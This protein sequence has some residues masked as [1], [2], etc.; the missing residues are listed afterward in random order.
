[1]LLTTTC[2]VQG[3]DKKERARS[4]FVSQK[5]YHIE[6]DQLYTN[7]CYLLQKSRRIINYKHWYQKF[8]ILSCYMYERKNGLQTVFSFI[9]RQNPKY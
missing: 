1:M 5:E 2:D 9:A 7:M 6:F 3:I 4:N 8:W